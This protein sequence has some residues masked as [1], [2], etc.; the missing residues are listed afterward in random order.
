MLIKK[1]LVATDFSLPSINLVDR[2]A[3]FKP[4]GLEEVLLVHVVDIRA[5]GGSA[6]SLQSI[7]E[8]V[9]ERKKRSLE[10]QGLKVQVMV[11][12]GFPAAEIVKI[13]Q[14]EQASMVAMTSHGKG[15][16]KQ[17]FLG[18]TTTDVI[19]SSTVPV[20][21]A[22]YKEKN[23]IKG[24]DMFRKVL[25]PLDFSVYSEKL[26]EQLLSIRHLVSEVIL[27]SV[28]ER[29]DNDDQL[30]QI[31]NERENKL[32]D[33]KSKLEQA[34]LKVQNLILQGTASVNIIQVADQED[35]SLIMMATRGEGLLQELILGSTAHAVAR[36][37]KQALVLM[38]LP[39][40]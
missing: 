21:I 35:V 23:K 26:L 5:P 16:I 37:C 12:I 28:I 6:V 33:E 30:L 15:I 13:A 22:K 19:R 36:R 27:L 8:E 4:F 32:M 14:K 24:A 3:E 29:A 1:V 9:L 38:P 25:L 39:R 10:D 34:G 2:L 17:I 20:L 18:S 11:P 31:I 40:D 7:D